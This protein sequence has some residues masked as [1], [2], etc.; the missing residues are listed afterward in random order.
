MDEKVEA[1]L[2][3]YDR[4]KRFLVSVL[5]DVQREYYYLPKEILIDVSQALDLPL[6]QIFCVATFFK[7]FSLE[8]RGR[9]QVNICIGTAC[10]VRG[11]TRVLES[12]ERETG[13]KPG[14]TDADLKFSLE[15]VNCLGCCALGPVMVVDG[16]YHGKL[17]TAKVAEILKGC[18]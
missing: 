5:Q 15:A 3:K 14:E 1:I 12:I 8:P 18:E 10:H 16:E 11:A 4:N 13:I 7:A 9:H 17:S 6:S 2:G